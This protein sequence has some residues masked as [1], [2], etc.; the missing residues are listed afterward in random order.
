MKPKEKIVDISH[1]SEVLIITAISNKGHF[2][3]CLQ[4]FDEGSP[5]SVEEIRSKTILEENLNYFKI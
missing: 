3:M 2:L 1:S 4:F 5:L